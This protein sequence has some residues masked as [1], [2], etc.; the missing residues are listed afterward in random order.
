MS[1]HRDAVEA[2]LIEQALTVRDLSWAKVVGVEVLK[3]V[4]DGA[5]LDVLKARF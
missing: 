4:L 1:T 3:K 2:V 5:N